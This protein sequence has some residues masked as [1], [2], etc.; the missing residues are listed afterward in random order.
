[1]Y[2]NSLTDCYSTLW[3]IVSLVG[4][5]VTGFPIQRNDITTAKDF[6]STQILRGHGLEGYTLLADSDTVSDM[7]QCTHS[8]LTCHLVCL[9]PNICSQLCV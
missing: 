7:Y 3:T 4:S 2:N 1:M 6:T 5:F 9:F 8:T